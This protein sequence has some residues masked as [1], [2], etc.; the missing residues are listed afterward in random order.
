M[1][2]NLRPLPI[3]IPANQN[4][5]LGQSLTHSLKDT[6]LLQS[7]GRARKY[8]EKVLKKLA[9]RK[10]LLG[11]SSTYKDHTMHVVESDMS[12]ATIDRLK[13]CPHFLHNNIN[14]NTRGQSLFSQGAVHPIVQS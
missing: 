11:Q 14:N 4:E 8:G 13:L 3:Y 2:L 1:E 7:S 9:K 6:W 12:M 10:S 5:L